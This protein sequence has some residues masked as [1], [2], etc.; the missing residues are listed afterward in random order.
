MS[1]EPFKVQWSIS[2]PP[3]AQYAKGDMLNVR[4]NSPEEVEEQFDA[5]LRGEFIDKATQVA[6]ELRATASVTDGLDAKPAAQSQPAQQQQSQQSSGA[7]S[8][9]H[10]ERKWVTGN[11]RTGAWAGWFCPLPKGSQGQCKPEFVDV[12]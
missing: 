10:G 7:P 8:C 3:A 6:H 11:G 1:D 4:G 9:A 2:L 5:I 12:A